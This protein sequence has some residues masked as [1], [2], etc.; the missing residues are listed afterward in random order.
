M[1]AELTESGKFCFVCDRDLLPQ[2]LITDTKQPLLGVRI[3][4]LTA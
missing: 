4:Q 2:V 1:E 3:V